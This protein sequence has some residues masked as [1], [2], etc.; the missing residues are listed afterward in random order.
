MFSS[1]L[2]WAAWA[3]IVLVAWL[4]WRA[5]TN[6][7]VGGT[8]D[9]VL[10]SASASFNA[11]TGKGKLPRSL[12][13]QRTAAATT[14]AAVESQPTSPTFSSPPPP[15]PPRTWMND[16]AAAAM[17]SSPSSSPP[18]PLPPR[19]EAEKLRVLN[20]ARARAAGVEL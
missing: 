9:S 20:E 10:S 14:A 2:D 12:L 4:L 19:N 16:V 17:S 7:G 5:N 13:R 11:T 3:I 1:P 15:L 6:E 8:S 18:P